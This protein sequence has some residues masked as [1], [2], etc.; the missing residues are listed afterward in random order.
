MARNITDLDE[1]E[2]I[3]DWYIGCIDKSKFY[4]NTDILENMY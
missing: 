3:S 1:Q 2:K 4:T